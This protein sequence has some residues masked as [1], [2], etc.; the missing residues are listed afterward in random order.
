MPLI[1][2]LLIGVVDLAKAFNYWNDANQIAGVGARMAAVNKNPGGTGITLQ[3]WIKSQG[4]TTEFRNGGTSG[5]SATGA[6]NVCI[7]TTD[8]DGNGSIT[9]GDSVT[10]QVT[11]T[12]SW[13]PFL[14]PTSGENKLAS[15][16][17]QVTLKGSA[18]MRLEAAP[19]NF[20]ATAC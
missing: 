3:D 10:V 5:D 19:T 12:Y 18:T 2:V 1:V 15:N 16:F 13:L 17:T 8:V 9:A 6:A 4:D 20:T 7:S 14:R 11:R